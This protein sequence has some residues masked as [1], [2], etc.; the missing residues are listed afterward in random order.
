MSGTLQ[1]F[2]NC[3]SR[4]LVT[5]LW[6]GIV[7]VQPQPGRLRLMADRDRQALKV[8]C[9][10]CQTLSETITHEFRSATN[11]PVSTMT[12][13]WE[14]RGMGFHGRADAHK[15]NFSPVNAKCYLQWCKEW[16]NWTVD[17][18]KRV[19]CGDEPWY[20]MWRSDGRVWVWRMPGERY[21]PACVMPTVKF[22]GGGITITVWG[23]FSWN[24]LGPV[25]IRHGNIN[26]EGY[27]DILTCWILPMIED[28]FGVD[29]CLYQ[30]DST[31]CHKSRSVRE[32]FVDN[33]VPEMDW[34]AQSPDLNP[35]EHLW[36]E[37]ER[38]LRSRPQRPTH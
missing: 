25:I 10:T 18:W 34:P 13:R 7:K 26:A 22:G 5:W 3:P 16:C 20:T 11:C 31:P 32:W 28:H 9:E 37:L 14:L 4:R 29:D 36:D 21:L 15:P 23:C 35:I 19:I 24:G 1:P 30:H 17:N 6:S 12:V 33:N 2:L 38:Q 8:V 27:K